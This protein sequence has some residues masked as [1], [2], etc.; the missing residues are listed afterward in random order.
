MIGEYIKKA[1]GESYSSLRFNNVSGERREGRMTV[2]EYRDQDTSVL[3]NDH[4]HYFDFKTIIMSE[5]AQESG[6]Y[7]EIANIYEELRFF[8]TNG[9]SGFQQ[10]QKGHRLLNLKMI[11]KASVFS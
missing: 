1:T 10:V 2:D 4:I 9:C 5:L 7:S 3:L 8:I 6:I 11:M